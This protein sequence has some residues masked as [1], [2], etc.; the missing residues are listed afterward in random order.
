MRSIGCF[1]TWSKLDR[2]MVNEAWTHG[3]SNSFANFLPS[4]CLSDHSP[5]IVSLFGKVDK[6]KIPF[7]FFNMW[8]NH[9]D[10]IKTYI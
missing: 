1:F 10:F 7:R 6:K 5:C 3:G 4:G 2:A 9:E 8:T